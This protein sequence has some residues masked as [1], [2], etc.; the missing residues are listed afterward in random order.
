MSWT[1]EPLGGASVTAERTRQAVAPG[2]GD[3]V[4]PSRY[5]DYPAIKEAGWKWPIPTYFF[6]GGVAAGSYLVAT[7]ADLF[8]S[9][10]DR[11]VS[12]AGRLVAMLMVLISPVLLTI[13]LGR[14]LRF[15]HMLRVVKTRSPMNLGTWGLSG[16][17]AFATLA[18]LRQA[19]EDG[20]FGRA[21][22]VGRIFTWVP[23]Q[24]SGVLGSL[25]AF[26]VGSYTGVLISF[27]NCPLWAKNTLLQG[28]LFLA[29][30]LSTGLAAT[31]LTVSLMGKSTTH[32]ESWLRRAEDA[33]TL[34]ELGLTV[35]TLAV[36]RSLAR[37]LIFGREAII[38][39]PAAVGLGLLA[40]LFL[41]R[42]EEKA[43]GSERHMLGLAAS[44]ATL[45]GGFAFRWTEAEA[46]RKS[47]D[48]PDYYFTFTK[49]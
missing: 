14:P 34:G 3:R 8:G 6:T 21:S 19:V 30:A 38:F 43:K 16:F 18:L 29:S 37:P 17:G 42:R 36:V 48:N 13:D 49:G 22:L 32:T 23:I 12:R 47:M 31:S 7:L 5:Y 28:P 10:E 35:G 33:A 39:W 9:K 44:V 11:A 41:R 46:G 26:F 25:L 1:T 15:T 2:F 4:G 40:P 27:T 45:V 20:L 24:V